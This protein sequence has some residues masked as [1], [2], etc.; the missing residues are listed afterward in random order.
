MRASSS[1]AAS[2]LGRHVSHRANRRAGTGEVRFG[3]LGPRGLIVLTARERDLGEAEIEHLG[4][5]ALGDENVGRLDV[6]VH[7]AFGMRGV[8]RVGDLDGERK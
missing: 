3:G 6:T 5:A 1:L 7:N 4:V 2:L 8:E